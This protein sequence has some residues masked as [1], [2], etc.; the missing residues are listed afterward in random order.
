MLVKSE[1]K[2]LGPYHGLL[3][4]NADLVIRAAKTLILPILARCLL[5]L[6]LN[7][8]QLAILAF[9]GHCFQFLELFSLGILGLPLLLLHLKIER[10]HIIDILVD[11]EVAAE[12]RIGS[13]H[14]IGPDEIILTLVNKLVDS[15]H[16]GQERYQCEVLVAVLLQKLNVLLL[17]Q[18]KGVL[19]RLLLVLVVLVVRVVRVHVRRRVEVI[20]VGVVP[21]TT[22]W[23]SWR[24][25]HIMPRHRLGLPAALGFCETH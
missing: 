7:V 15:S 25:E 2:P 13:L 22:V 18:I 12:Q 8:A 10:A 11:F 16:L 21:R 9:S 3:D 5:S 6:L 1:I 20:V 17:R 14:P 19:A 23:T 4:I 24:L